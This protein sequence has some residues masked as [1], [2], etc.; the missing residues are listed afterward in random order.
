MAFSNAIDKP[1]RIFK[2]KHKYDWIEITG[3]M[4]DV[5]FTVHANHQNNSNYGGEKM[6]ER[7][8][9]CAHAHT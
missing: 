3:N 4:N 1:N 7:T 5:K 9:E 6:S 8:T 2:H